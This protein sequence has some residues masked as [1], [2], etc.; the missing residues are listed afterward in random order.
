[1]YMQNRTTIQLSNTL[2]KEL[3]ELAAKRDANYQELLEDMI[4]VFNELDKDKTIISLPKKLANN[5]KDKIK[6]TDFRTVSEYTTF[7]LRLMLYEEAK[8]EK[9]DE[10]KIKDRLK[11]LG[12]I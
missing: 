12:Y 1:M 6:N 7:L 9:V 10:K 11:K 3:R 5:V 8:K 2:R 4:E